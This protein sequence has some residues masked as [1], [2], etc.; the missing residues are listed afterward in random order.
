MTT[1]YGGIFSCLLSDSQHMGSVGDGRNG[2]TILV[3]APIEVIIQHSGAMEDAS[4]A[5][6]GKK[7]AETSVNAICE[8]FRRKGIHA[9]GWR[10]AE[11]LYY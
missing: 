9:A 1:G 6:F 8:A 2:A 10:G 11:A 5:R 3:S 4:A 7:I